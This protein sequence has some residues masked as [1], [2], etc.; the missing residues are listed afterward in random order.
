MNNF[1]SRS[2]CEFGPKNDGGRGRFLA[3]EEA[4]LNSFDEKG[5]SQ[6]LYPQV[7]CP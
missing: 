1:L 2:H 7:V 4:L 5:V 3:L 6:P